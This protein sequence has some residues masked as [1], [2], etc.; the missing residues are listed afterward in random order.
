[1][2]AL[3]Q[4]RT[5]EAVQHLASS[6]ARSGYEYRIYR[7]GL[8]QAY[9]GAGRL[10][11]AREEALQVIRQQDLV[12]PRSDLWLDRNRA[13]LVLARIERAMGQPAAAAGRAR[14]FL[15]AWKRADPGMPEV[16]QARELIGSGTVPMPAAT[17]W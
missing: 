6:V 5:K 4:G 17:P 3:G 10:A 1:M 16:G 12:E 11:E 9:L 14:E 13:L 7:L 2:A 8:A 15:T